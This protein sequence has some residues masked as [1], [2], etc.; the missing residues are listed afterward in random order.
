MFARGQQLKTDGKQIYLLVESFAF[1]LWVLVAGLRA[2]TM[3]GTW[4][5]SCARIATAALPAPPA[6]PNT[7]LR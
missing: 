5:P 2:Q 3:P 7:W 6:A 4:W 1:P